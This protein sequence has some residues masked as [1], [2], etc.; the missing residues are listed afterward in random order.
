M[1][2]HTTIKVKDLKVFSFIWAF[3][4]LVIGVYPLINSENPIVFCLVVSLFFLIVGLVKPTLLTGF[5][6]VWVKFGEFIGGIISK[7][8]ILTLFYGMFTPIAIVLKILGKDLLNK[9]LDKESKSY[10]LIREKQPE[11]MKYQF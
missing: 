11:S 1:T 5:Y 9:K 7:I 6:K 2:A 10:W 8:I 4:F 3:I